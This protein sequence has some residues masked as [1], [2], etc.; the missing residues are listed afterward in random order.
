MNELTKEEKQRLFGTENP[1]YDD[2]RSV[3][4]KHYQELLADIDK[5][6][7][8]RWVRGNTRSMLMLFK[9]TVKMIAI[10]QESIID[11]SEYVDTLN[12]AI[13]SLN[14]IVNMT[15]N[16]DLGDLKDVAK[17]QKE[18]NEINEKLKVQMEQEKLLAFQRIDKIRQEL[19][20][21]AVV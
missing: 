9:G 2:I 15:K 1:T 10:D 4:K 20:R 13:L 12:R 6:L 21:D 18:L 5:S 7:K 8:S 14:N 3:I 17:Q 16:K 19:L 11:L